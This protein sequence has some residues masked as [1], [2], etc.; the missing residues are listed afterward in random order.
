MT[1]MDISPYSFLVVVRIGPDIDLARQNGMMHS[2]I[3]LC[4]LYESDAIGCS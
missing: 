2:K 3:D 4:Y 1:C